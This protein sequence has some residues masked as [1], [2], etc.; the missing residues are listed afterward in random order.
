MRDGTTLLTSH[1]MCGPLSPCLHTSL[2]HGHP[3]IKVILPGPGNCRVGGGEQGSWHLK[4][5]FQVLGLLA[6]LHE[7]Q[8]E[9]LEVDLMLGLLDDLSQQSP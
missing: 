7:P 1:M 5:H 3:Y 9:S 2:A 4:F 6:L 8:A